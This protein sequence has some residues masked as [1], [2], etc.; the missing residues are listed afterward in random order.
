M[1]M[2][3]YVRATQL[4]TDVSLLATWV[5]SPGQ[6][7]AFYNTPTT[8][9]FHSYKLDDGTLS[10]W[11]RQAPAR[12]TTV[13]GARVGP[14]TAGFNPSGDSRDIIHVVHGNVADRGADE[15][16]TVLVVAVDR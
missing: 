9:R 16:G 8:P 14:R 3:N 15:V 13:A 4:Q 7:N 10:S 6:P 1:R 11:Q 5:D 2:R 12:P